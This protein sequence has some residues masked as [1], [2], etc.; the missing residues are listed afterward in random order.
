MEPR[1]FINV[2]ENDTYMY[3]R[4]KVLIPILDEYGIA[5]TEI[6]SP[7]GHSGDYWVSN[8]AEYFRWLSLDWR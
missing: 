7:G 2:G 1:V 4:A 6:F 8:F 5:H 3:G